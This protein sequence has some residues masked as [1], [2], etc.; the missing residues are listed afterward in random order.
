MK[1]VTAC[2]DFSPMLHFLHTIILF[3]HQG[4]S[5][6]QSP[7]LGQTSDRALRLQSSQ[8]IRAVGCFPTMVVLPQGAVCLLQKKPKKPENYKWGFYLSVRDLAASTIN[9]PDRNLQDQAIRESQNHSG[10][11]T[12]QRSSLT[13]LQRW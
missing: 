12:P 8:V 10:W 5:L 4:S 3:L 7:P 11:K 1:A 9:H 13:D 2:K 6:D